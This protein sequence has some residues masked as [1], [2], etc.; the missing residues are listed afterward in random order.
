MLALIGFSRVINPDRPGTGA[1]MINGALPKPI[2]LH[3]VADRS[4]NGNF[5]FPI[6]PC[7]S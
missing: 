1:S 3:A 6:F 4:V 5:V 2:I 7:M